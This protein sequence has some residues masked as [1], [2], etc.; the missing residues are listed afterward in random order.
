MRLMVNQRQ[1]LILTNP[2]PCGGRKPGFGYSLP[3]SV[4]LIGGYPTGELLEQWLTK[5][6]GYSGRP[7]PT[8]LF[9]QSSR[10]MERIR[11]MAVY[12]FDIID[13]ARLSSPTVVITGEV[14]E[15]KQPPRLMKMV[16]SHPLTLLLICSVERLY[17]VAERI[18]ES[19]NSPKPI[20]TI[21]PLHPLFA[22]ANVSVLL[23]GS[24]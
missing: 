2:I 14:T 10:S 8:H 6:Y 12:S 15:Q 4:Q 21:L 17:Q 11:R 23:G 5:P 19:N 22:D 1:R 7:C 3:V 18:T 9:Q 20:I 13:P 16:A 24:L